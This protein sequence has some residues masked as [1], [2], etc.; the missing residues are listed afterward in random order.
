MKILNIKNMADFLPNNKTHKIVLFEDNPEIIAQPHNLTTS[1][2][3]WY[4]FDQDAMIDAELLIE[5]GGVTPDRAENFA[6]WLPKHLTILH[7]GRRL[8]ISTVSRTGREL[9]SGCLLARTHRTPSASSC[10]MFISIPWWILPAG[11]Q[12]DTSGRQCRFQRWRMR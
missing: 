2:R 3:L 11:D 6:A 5:K 1:A 8:I 12:V 7:C 9:I 4:S 10:R